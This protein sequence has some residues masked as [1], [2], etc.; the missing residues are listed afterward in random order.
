MHQTDVTSST[1]APPSTAGQQDQG[2]L[3]PPDGHSTPSPSK[4]VTYS[5]RVKSALQQPLLPL[6][7]VQ[8]S[9]LK[10]P[11][12]FTPR[13]SK[14]LAAS[15]QKKVPAAERIQLLL[16]ARLGLD[17]GSGSE[18][19][20]AL[21]NFVNLFDNQLSHEHIMALAALFKIPVPESLPSGC[22]VPTNTILTSAA[23]AAS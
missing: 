1:T 7:D 9:C 8:R 11:A 13:R 5:R 18:H 12:G 22:E 6:P 3:L 21:R 14:R 4:L 16:A 17:K 2:S 20:T 23:L 19:R 10:Q 15:R